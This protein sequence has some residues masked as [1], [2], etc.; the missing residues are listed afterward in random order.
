MTMKILFVISQLDYADHIAIAYLSAIAKQL[1]HSTYFCSLDN[2]DL[3]DTIKDIMPD[4]VAYSV[5]IMGFSKIV[6]EHKKAIK[7]HKFISIMGG[8]QATFSPET[9]DESGM[10]AYC[11]GEGEYAFRDFLIRIEK[12]ESFDD[13]P[14]LITRDKE[15]KIIINPVRHL[16][17]NLD[18]LPQADRDLTL[19]NSFLKNTP[20]K[21]FYTTRG[22]PF[23]CA[24]CCNNYYHKLYKGK[25]QIVR[26]FSVERIIREIE[27][28][29]SKYR[30]EFIKFED[31]MFATK[32]D[33]WLEE[34][35]EKYSKRIGIPFN[36]YLRFDRVDDDVLRLLKMAG[37][38]SVHLSVDSTSKHV[39][40][41]ILR[42]R[43]KDVDIVRQLKKIR[44]YGINT[45]VNHMLAVPESTLQD[46]LDTIKLNKEADV[47]YA[48]YSTTVPMKGT[49]LYNY[50][51]EK[52][53]IDPIT[54]KGDMTGCNLEST[55]YCFTERE[56]NIR[57][58]IYLLGAIIAKLP[59]PLFELTIYMIKV[60]PPN[61]L[62]KKMRSAYFEY[63]IKNTIFKLK[64]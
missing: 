34:F 46:D 16:I 56:K 6:E 5:N 40:E 31:D 27:D 39:R 57:Y 59:F 3:I 49:E 51:V 44:E 61:E 18:E 45:W 1:N 21:T 20:K 32:V 25:G 36:C 4:V 17:T 64:D 9:F 53:I 10:D 47:T 30:T 62:F 7:V 11:I 2:K 58:N 19:S 38:Y 29:K 42:R 26:R 43:M 35:A 8:P 52:K 12:G 41:S 37:C 54:H 33:E 14:N 48:A 63:S 50:C 24:Y 55:L 23:E 28:V 15:N 13:V 22:C 60:I